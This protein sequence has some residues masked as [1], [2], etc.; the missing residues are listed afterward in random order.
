MAD[1]DIP[2]QAPPVSPLSVPIFR[3]VWLASLASNFGTVIQSVGASWM[4]VSLAGS[5]TM[6][7]LVQSST[8]LPIML[9]ALIAGAIADS[10][11]RRVIMILAQ[12]LMLTAAAGL[13]ICGLLGVLTP[14]MLLGFTFLIGCGTAFNG[15]AWQASVGEMVP[16][17][18]LPGAIAL[19]SMAFNIARSLGPAIGGAIVAAAGAAAAF[20]ANAFSYL[21]LI[22]V[23]LRWKPEQPARTLPR[24]TLGRAMGAGIR[25]VLMSPPLRT[26]LMRSTM[27]GVSAIAI[28]ALMPL[29]ARDLIA[30]GP[31][32]FGLLLG[33]FGLGS[34]AG[35]LNIGRIRRHFSTEAITRAASLGLAI[36]AAV[37][38]LSHTLWTALPALALAGSGWVLALSTFNASIQLGSPRWVVARS[39]SIYQMMTFGGM[40]IGG[41]AFG[42]VAEAFGVRDA[43]FAA[44]ACQLVVVLTGFVQRLPEVSGE[45]LDP[46][47]RWKE[48]AT[49]VAIEGRSG[50]IV[51]T[52]DYRVAPE[53]RDRFMDVMEERRRIRLR[54]GARRWRLL[55]ALDDERHWLERY[56]VPTWFDYVRHNQRRTQ[57]DIENSLRIKE[58]HE[59]PWP[60]VVHEMIE[61]PPGAARTRRDQPTVLVP[62][63]TD[64]TR[65]S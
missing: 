6:V 11:D 60:P 17:P 4:M 47:N 49:A 54:D 63:L 14:W 58:L 50:P 26:I 21:G 3:M 57:A 1:Q 52:I 46:L 22:A 48:P 41:W 19:N 53:N 15:P 61:R 8:T 5:A 45:N 65:Y 38:G 43:L 23:L 24:E 32:T 39:L 33:G 18:A 28:S 59:G 35:A 56:Q 12:L 42:A 2:Q 20:L 62:P 44:A 31:I 16:R 37:T 10:F 13:A 36:G 40:A 51:V 30:G 9:L 27:F 64:P 7:A 25:Y 55:N 34:V 29:V